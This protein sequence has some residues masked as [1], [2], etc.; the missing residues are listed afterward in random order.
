MPSN[1]TELWQ[2]DALF[3]ELAELA[4]ARVLELYCSS[5]CDITQKGDGSPLTSADLA[6]DH[7][8]REG[9]AKALPDIPIVSEEAI[10]DR[11]AASTARFILVDPLDGTKEFCKRTGEFT[12]NIALIDEGRP[13]VGVV[14]APAIGRLWSGYSGGG[15]EL[16]SAGPGEPIAAAEASSI[17]TRIPGEAGLVAV[18]SR[19]HLDPETEA[20]LESLGIAQTASIGSSLKFCLLAQG[21]ADVYARFAP[22]MAWDTAAGHAVLDAAGGC[23]CRADGTPLR[24]APSERGWLNPHFI[25]WANDD[26][27]RRMTKAG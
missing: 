15:A 24:Y 5:D 17:T 27:R 22:T 6:S 23:V 18:A 8:I 2:V 10:P 20:F 13:I 12:V 14:Y 16:R 26:L 21:E 25:A 4:G 3:R 7:V 1:E 11:L 19:S 9:L